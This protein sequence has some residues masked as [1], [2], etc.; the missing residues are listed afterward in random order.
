M[1]KLRR[2]QFLLRSMALAMLAGARAQAQPRVYRIGTLVMTS[3]AATAQRGRVFSDRLA[4]LGYR[5]GKNLVYERRYAEARLERLPELAAELVAQKPDVIFVGAGPA[6]LAV[7]KATSTIPIV[8]VTVADPVGMGLV[9]SLSRPGTNV[10]GISTLSA[11]LHGKRLQ[12]LKEAF[13]AAAKVVVLHGPPEGVQSPALATL[14]EASGTLGV[15][16]RPIEAKTEQD[17]ATA[18][19][20]LAGEQSVV[21][22]VLEGSLTYLHRARIVEQASSARIPAVYGQAEFAEAGGL[23]SYSYSLTEHLRA[24]ANCI[25]RILKGAK[26]ADLPVEQPTR[27]ELVLNLKTAKAQDVKFPPAILL[28]ADRVIE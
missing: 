8:F 7:A 6:A 25:D 19:K 11:D 22:Y 12:L 15:V 21:L 3:A 20:S 14:R 5:E 24:A 4:E 18:F 10:T 9:K 27:F 13:P 16:L 1:S 2:R 23:M 17:I 26:P 28:R